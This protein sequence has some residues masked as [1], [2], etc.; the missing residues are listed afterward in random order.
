M[1]TPHAW[2]SEHGQMAAVVSSDRVC[3]FLF[4]VPAWT[5]EQG[6]KHALEIQEKIEGVVPSFI[7]EDPVVISDEKFRRCTAIIWEG[8][9]PKIE[10]ADELYS[11]FNA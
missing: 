7:W 10:D 11:I 8:S 4:P 5:R 3:F 1:D 9:S 6:E 2:K